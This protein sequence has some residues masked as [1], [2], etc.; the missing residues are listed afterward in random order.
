MSCNEEG[1][2]VRVVKVV[3]SEWEV[4]GVSTSGEGVGGGIA[5]VESDLGNGGGC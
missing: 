4:D 2:V 5:V 3:G 1:A